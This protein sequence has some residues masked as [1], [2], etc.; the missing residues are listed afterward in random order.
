[1]TT[2][3]QRVRLVS[4]FLLVFYCIYIQKEYKQTNG[5]IKC[6]SLYDGYIKQYAHVRERLSPINVANNYKNIF[7]I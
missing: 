3:P 2:S 6:N 1:M 7:N 4:Y 5:E